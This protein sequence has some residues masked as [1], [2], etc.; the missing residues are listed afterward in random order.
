MWNPREQPFL[1]NL[2]RPDVLVRALHPCYLAAFPK[3]KSG[4]VPL[5]IFWFLLTYGLRFAFP[6]W[7][8]LGSVLRTVVVDLIL[9]R[10]VIYRSGWVILA[11]LLLLLLLW[12]IFLGLS[13]IS[14]H[15]LLLIR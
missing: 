5:L 7:N 14:H 9:L 13:F 12:I 8:L 6:R 11:S 15:L 1:P 3:N 10:G 2:E 4:S